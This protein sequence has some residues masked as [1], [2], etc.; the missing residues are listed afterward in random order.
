MVMMY[1]EQVN[2]REDYYK[3]RKIFEHNI[4]LPHPTSKKDKGKQ[5][6]RKL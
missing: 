6:G 5:R 3:G 2:R 4:V 1:A